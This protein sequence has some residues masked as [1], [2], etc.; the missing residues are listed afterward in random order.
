MSISIKLRIWAL[1][2]LT[3]C[4]L[5]AG[6]AVSLQY[7]TSA[8]NRISATEKSDYPTLDNAKRLK[9]DVQQVADT[10]KDVVTEGDKN[11]LLTIDDLP[12]KTHVTIDALAQIPA[13]NKLA[14]ELT[15]DFNTYYTAAVKVTKVMLEV[16]AGDPQTLVEAMQSAQK[17][18]DASIAKL[19]T[20]AQHE[21]EKGVKESQQNVRNALIASVAAAVL[22]SL[23]L[24]LI[25]FLVVRAI[26]SQ[27]GGEPEYVRKLVRAVA[28]GD[29]SM[30]INQNTNDQHSLLA[31]MADMQKKLQTM[32][33]DVKSSTNTLRAASSDIA[34]ATLTLAERTESQ[35]S[36]LEE[37][38]ASMETLTARVQENAQA[39][40]QANSLGNEASNVA[41]KGGEAVGRVVATMN[42]IHE[43]AKKIVD[44]IS[45]IDGIAFQTNILALNAAVEAARAGEQ[46]R[47]FAVVASEVR[48]LAQRSAAAAKEIKG[49]IAD[50]VDKVE[51]G[52]ALVRNAGTTMSEVVSSIQKVTTLLEQITIA[53][54]E[55][56]NELISVNEALTEI[57]TMTQQNTALV[58]EASITAATMAEQTGSLD[59]SLS[60]FKVEANQ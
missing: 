19:N 2:A 44:I 39:A 20:D 5:A 1:P 26:W 17:K 21:F 8:L 11:R 13:Q 34:T 47:G 22:A 41:L 54:R 10:L 4:V 46:G 18:L 15:Q 42:D 59:Q 6:T 48:S 45:V 28:E 60:V 43:S 40:G 52:N 51:T 9:T 50:S 12:K 56:S 14:K 24:I 37:T 49:L 35:A 7:S 38:S 23:A 31:A 33:Y 30:H 53:S 29:F 36:R 27:L 25:C 3:F 58:A 16:E 32:M 57:D 55:Q